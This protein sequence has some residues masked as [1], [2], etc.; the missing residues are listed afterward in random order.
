MSGSNISNI[1]NNKN[2]V[3]E[4]TGPTTHVGKP[5][6]RRGTPGNRQPTTLQGFL[7]NILPFLDKTIS[8]KL[9]KQK[10]HYNQ[11]PLWGY[12]YFAWW[13]TC[14]SIS[15]KDEN[16]LALL[17]KQIS[18]FYPLFKP[19]KFKPRKRKKKTRRR[20]KKG[21]E[22]NSCV[23]QAE[24]WTHALHAFPA[25]QHSIPTHWANLKQRVYVSRALCIIVLRS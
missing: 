6:T 10:K 23:S 18:L 3:L 8:T 24:S 13:S 25:F 20:E 15:R 21:K 14:I 12:D 11:R 17:Q 9:H 5:P 22:K 4:Q 7:R 19:R 16:T 1:S 2:L